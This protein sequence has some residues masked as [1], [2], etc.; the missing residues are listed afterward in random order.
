[1]QALLPRGQVCAARR[2]RERGDEEGKTLLDLARASSI[3]S[4]CVCR[5]VYLASLSNGAVTTAPRFYC[6]CLRW[7]RSLR[8]EVGPIRRLAP[9]WAGEACLSHVTPRESSAT[10]LALVR[11][12]RTASLR[13]TRSSFCAAL[14]K[15]PGSDH[16]VS[17][18][19]L[20]RSRSHVAH[21]SMSVGAVLGVRHAVAARPPLSP[22]PSTPPSIVPIVVRPAFEPDH[23][24]WGHSVQCSRLTRPCHGD[25]AWP[26]RSL[27]RTGFALAQ[28]GP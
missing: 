10:A 14:P 13:L 23:A 12:F 22:V 6:L 4:T 16:T 24:P 17:L 25:L 2:A 20:K 1:M 15:S 19:P 3:C 5:A 27:R 11:P 18:T 9:A 26:R 28:G 21:T 7:A 8:L